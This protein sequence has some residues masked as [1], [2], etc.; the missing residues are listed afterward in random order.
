MKRTG[1]SWM[2][3][4]MPACLLSPN[5]KG[6]LGLEAMAQAVPR[7]VACVRHCFDEMCHEV[8]SF[9]GS[10][11]RKEEWST[12]QG[13]ENLATGKAAAVAQ[14][15]VVDSRADDVAA[16]PLLKPR[17]I[18][19]ATIFRWV[20]ADAATAMAIPI[21]AHRVAPGGSRGTP[22]AAP[23]IVPTATPAVLSAIGKRGSPSR[24][25]WRA[26]PN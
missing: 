23:V 9:L 10:E 13:R 6:L 2:V 4:F 26:A 25:T 17:R 15:R 11:V 14:V 1:V 20:V 3:Q 24:E 18:T 12:A 21:S 16:M 5:R 7:C 22:P 8:V 19:P